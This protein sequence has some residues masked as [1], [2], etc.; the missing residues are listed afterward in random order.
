MGDVGGKVMERFRL[1]IWQGRRDKKAEQSS[2][3]QVTPC[4]KVPE[5][6]HENLVDRVGSR[7]KWWAEGVLSVCSQGTAREIWREKREGERSPESLE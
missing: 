2:T 6:T 5:A 1:E 4:G 3:P 7:L